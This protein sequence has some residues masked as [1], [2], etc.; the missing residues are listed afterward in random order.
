MA[1]NQ[2][3]V[4]VTLGAEKPGAGKLGTEKIGAKKHLA[5]YKY[6]HVTRL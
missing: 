1:D 4:T 3:L 2:Y 5:Q 6:M